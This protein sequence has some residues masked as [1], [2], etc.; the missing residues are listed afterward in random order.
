ME[1][2]W[3]KLETP[4]FSAGKDSKATLCREAVSAHTNDYRDVTT[5]EHQLQ[6][7]SNFAA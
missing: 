1:E 6:S 4:E 3:C 5:G 7:Q 2:Q